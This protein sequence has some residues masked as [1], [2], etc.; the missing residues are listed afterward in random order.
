MAASIPNSNTAPMVHFT[1]SRS[2]HQFILLSEQRHTCVNNLPRVAPSG[3]TAG[4]RTR[5]LSITNPT[6]YH[7]TT[8]PH[9]SGV[10]AEWIVQKQSS[11]RVS[12]LFRQSVS[13]LKAISLASESDD[14]DKI[15]KTLMEASYKVVMQWIPGNEAA[16][17][18]AKVVTP[19]YSRPIILKTVGYL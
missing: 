17:V 14:T 7:Y 6:L 10:A 2:R 11:G 12:D 18:A 8:K 5:S 3:G 19:K 9:S 1:S 13:L 16:D 15:R 4:N